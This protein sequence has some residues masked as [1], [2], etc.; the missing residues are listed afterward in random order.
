[1]AST[2]WSGRF[3]L[4]LYKSTS[5][6]LLRLSMNFCNETSESELY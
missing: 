2:L 1:M 4:N 6:L 3:S 5:Y